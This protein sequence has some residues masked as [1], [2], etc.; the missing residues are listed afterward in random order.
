[1]SARSLSVRSAAKINLHLRV[2][3]PDASGFHPLRSW[4]TSVALF[5]N[6]S[7][8]IDPT[9]S[10]LSASRDDWFTLTCDDPALRCDDSNLI[11]R[12]AAAFA[13]AVPGARTVGRVIASLQKRIP[14]GGGLGGGSSNAAA[15]LLALNALLPD[16]LGVEPLDARTLHTLGCALGSDVAFFL[17]TPSAVMT[18]RG[19]H[20]ESVAV[21]AV[22]RFALLMFPPFGVNTAACYRRLDALRPIAPSETLEPID[23]GAWSRLSSRDLLAKLVNDLEVPA[24]DLAPELVRLKLDCE[25]TLGQTVRMSGSGST[26]FTLFDTRGEAD[27][28]SRSLNSL[29]RC[30]VAEL[31]VPPV[32]VEMR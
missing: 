17:G 18:G 31:C 26:L 4:V 2:A 22:A 7:F 12:A 25:H 19:E 6:L 27:I 1:M 14:M 11:V 15:T 20:I 23:V 16:V 5:D 30:E 21:P 9:G 28:A 13:G 8:A 24:F 29:I 32:D 10:G 3:G